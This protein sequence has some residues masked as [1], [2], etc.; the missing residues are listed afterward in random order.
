MSCPAISGAGLLVRQY[1]EEGWYPKGYAN[2]PDGFDPSGALVKATLLNASVDMTGVPGYPSDKE[3]WGRLLLDNALF[4]EGEGRKLVIQDVRNANGMVTGESRRFLIRVLDNSQPLKITMVYSDYPAEINANPATV[5]DL[6]LNVLTISGALW[7]GNNINTST[8][9]SN[10][11]GA[12]DPRNTVE[13]VILKQP[14]PGIYV[15]QVDARA[16]NLGGK[17]GYAVVCSGNI[18]LVTPG[19]P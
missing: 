19:G 9:E 17:Q 16:V 12:N 2:A 15:I 8:G 6:D 1:Y 11:F 7:R 18:R 10:Q 14:Q 13:M 3:G 5:N 4:F